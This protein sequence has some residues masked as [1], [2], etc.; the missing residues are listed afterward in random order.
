MNENNVNIPIDSVHI[1]FQQTFPNTAGIFEDGGM[2]GQ[3]F[4][5]Q[6]IDIYI[7]TDKNFV[8]VFGN[9][10]LAY[11]IKNPNYEMIFNDILKRNMC[12]AKN[13]IRYWKEKDK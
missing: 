3:A 12:T 2:S 4:I 9:D 13:C 5:T 7:D 1:D 11:I 8:Y 6:N 10:K